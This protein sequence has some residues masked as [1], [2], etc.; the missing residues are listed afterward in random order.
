[1]H[2]QPGQA[3]TGY[4]STQHYIT[5][6]YT[7]ASVGSDTDGT[8][9]WYF[10]PD[11][12]KDGASAPGLIFLHG[13]TAID[14]ETYY[15]HIVHL[16]K[17]GY[18]VIYP[19]YQVSSKMGSTEDLDQSVMLLRAVASVDAALA[20]LYMSSWIIITA[21]GHSLGGLF[22]FCWTGA[23]GAAVR[24]IVMSHANMDP[25]TGIPAF[26]LKPRHA[27]RLHRPSLRPCRYRNAGHHCSGAAAIPTS[28]RIAQQHA[29]L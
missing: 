16:V 24:R 18:I 19:V 29:R 17:Q 23:G 15:G 13:Y 1:M 25:S 4:G 11:T 9:A 3:D 14:P 22:A 5:D 10:V 21:Y 2:S 12:L 28:P 8:Q 27:H 6:T 20:E 7:R 26:A